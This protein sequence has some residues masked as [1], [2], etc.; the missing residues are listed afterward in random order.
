VRNSTQDWPWFSALHIWQKGLIGLVLGV[1]V[2][3]LLLLPNRLGMYI[4]AGG[5][6]SLIIGVVIGF[7][8]AANYFENSD[9]LPRIAWLVTLASIVSAVAVAL[10]AFIFRTSWVLW[11]WTASEGLGAIAWMLFTATRLTHRSDAPPC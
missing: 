9:P 11:F 1:A 6:A 2:A 5:V 7:R 8:V 3:I 4:V 10:T